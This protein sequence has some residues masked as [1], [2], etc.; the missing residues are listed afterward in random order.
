MPYDPLNFANKPNDL[1][2]TPVDKYALQMAEEE[3]RSDQA[4]VNESSQSVNNIKQQEQQTQ[5]DQTAKDTKATNLDQE[6][7]ALDVGK[8]IQEY[9]R[10][11]LEGRNAVVGG[12]ID[13]AE[14]VGR[15]TGAKWLNLDDSLTPQNTTEWGKA[16]RRI[17]SVVGPN[18]VA[19]AATRKSFGGLAKDWPG[20]SSLTKLNRPI[21]AG[22]TGAAGAGIG[23][24][25]DQISRES[26]DMNLTG[27]L[28]K[29]FPATFGWIPDDIATL[30]TDSP[31][32]K[33]SKNTWEGFGLNPLTEGIVYLAKAA[34][35]LKG[36]VTG[37]KIIPL[38]DT[39]RVSVAKEAESLKPVTGDPAVDSVIRSI[40]A[41]D[42]HETASVMDE[43][44]R[45]PNP[46]NPTPR[47]NP[48]LFSKQETGI[49]G[50][51]PNAV[52]RAMVDAGRI[53][54]NI[55]TV[56]G[57]LENIVTEPA[58]RE[59][60]DA[61]LEGKRTVV[62]GISSGIRESGKFKAVTQL[63]KEVDPR[64]MDEGMLA[65]YKQIIDPDN[66]IDDL[67]D[68]F[69]DEKFINNNFKVAGKGIDQITDRAYTTS[70]L[71][72]KRL[73]DD[74]MGVE[75]AK[76]SALAINSTAG[77]VVSMAS[78]V[79]ILGNQINTGE[80]QQ[81]I[82]DKVEFLLNE[83]WVNSYASGM[84][85]RNKGFWAKA[86][87]IADMGRFA[88]E[89]NADI[90]EK[91]AQKA[92]QNKEFVDN[93]RQISRDNPEY[94]KPLME[95]YDLTNGNVR[96]INAL[97]G[98]FNKHLHPAG[99][100]TKGIIDGEPNVPNYVQ[101]G[102]WSTIYNSY[103]SSTAT[104]T[105]AWVG[106]ATM[107]INKPL[108]SLLGAGLDP[109]LLKRNWVKYGA[110]GDSFQKAAEYARTQTK[111]IFDDPVKY[112][113]IDRP[114]LALM[115]E[116]RWMVLENVAKARQASGEE[117][118]M[119]M[120]NMA[121]SLRDL[122]NWS[123]VRY[124]ANLM[125][126]GDAFS[127]AF[128]A[129]ADARAKAYDQL[130]D[131]GKEITQ[132]TLK[133]ASERMYRDM[134]D[135]DGIIRGETVDFQTKEVAMALDGPASQAVSGLVKAMPILKPF[136]LFPRTTGN[137]LMMGVKHTPLTFFM[138][139]SRIAAMPSRAT[140]EDIAEFMN[141]RGIT[142]YSH[143]DFLE[144]TSEV[145][146]RVALGAFTVFGANQLLLQGRL[147][148]NPPADKERRSAME[149]AMG[150]AYWNS[151]KGPDGQWHSHAPFQ[152]YSSILAASADL[153]TL[154]WS[155]P[156]QA[157]TEELAQKLIYVVGLNAANKSWT[158]G[159]AQ[160]M[161]LT[162]GDM[163]A[164]NRTVASLGNAV[165]PGAG[166]RGQVSRIY[167]PALREVENDIGQ[168]M[169]NRNGW[170]DIFDPKGKLP[171][172]RDIFN[173]DI[174]NN[175]NLVN[176][177]VNASTPFKINIDKMT[178]GRQLL[179]DS[180]FDAVPAITKYSGSPDQYTTDQR[181]KI[182]AYMGIYG[183]VDKQLNE[184]AS[185]KWVKDE[186]TAII[187][188]RREGITS[189]DFDT[190]QGN[191]HA[192]IRRIIERAKNFGEQ[193]MLNETPE[194]RTKVFDKRQNEMKLRTG[195][196]D[197]LINLPNGK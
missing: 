52:R 49:H 147:T 128:I 23:V 84:A 101:Q 132:A 50:I 6:S 125:G 120:Y 98:W 48:D 119:A 116:D 197:Q 130:L 113:A 82:L 59:G 70:M 171:Y 138:R 131:E 183:D 35:G 104:F 153:S 26:E 181:S 96:T 72:I 29:E 195:Q 149:K 170:L 20:I 85:L 51:R 75:A 80:V 68:V 112:G 12:F 57:V 46:E 126:S 174:L 81:R 140:P 176:R 95:A 156:N 16:A 25:I 73:M 53:H 7:S 56:D 150:G 69:I 133:E 19:L 22:L 10:I 161:D 164:F 152:P 178:P 186:M 41:R 100:I 45:N 99:L 192:E 179:I 109:E 18:L 106:N 160:F 71:A 11:G 91:F 107:L 5:A 145:R 43:F 2:N 27:T 36:M 88:K 182:A 97:N 180:G 28:K 9:A 42:T 139:E 151:I 123:G 61:A 193:K 111:K 115:D 143:A 188:A 24:G 47:M 37:T 121:K 86:R 155:N 172:A 187:K 177:L 134:F 110:V 74:Y 166:L 89:A 34:K 15:K 30:D 31:D 117:G 194:I 1:E 93:L 14:D 168:Y 144:A 167:D 158:Q 76:A 175:H 78:G 60:L 189:K 3:L 90:S 65:M 62:A 8:G 55:D 185:K 21:Q 94:L 58:L 127:R 4:V 64:T 165:I 66:K 163:G 136:I 39:A 124:S 13:F 33:R 40:E 54:K 118:P 38:D 44:K 63:G 105:S 87:N 83:T 122:N 141:G 114:D 129:S 159:I 102:I 108:S 191:V 67:A 169:R 103:L 135:S 77:E 154:F 184:L 137:M 79:K 32:V 196:Y 148:G 146:G 17:V 142:K 92:A 173:G 162:S 190:S 157:I